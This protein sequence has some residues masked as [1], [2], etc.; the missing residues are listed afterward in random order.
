MARE[1]NLSKM[2]KQLAALQ[3]EVALLR[4][5]EALKIG[6]LCLEEGLAVDS[7]DERALRNFIKEGVARFRA[8]SGNSVDSAVEGASQNGQIAHGG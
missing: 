4:D 3:E 1:K 7:A 2:E 6:H 5:R 8:A